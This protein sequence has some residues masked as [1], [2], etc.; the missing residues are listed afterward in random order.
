VGHYPQFCRL[1][2]FTSSSSKV[3]EDAETETIIVELSR[4]SL[5]LVR[6]DGEFI[7]YRAHSKQLE[8][9]SIL[10]LTPSSTRPSPETIE[11]INHEYSLRSELDKVWALP[12]LAI[13]SYNDRRVLVLEDPGGAPLNRVVEGPMEIMLFLRLA[14]QISDAVAQL[15]R[16]G[17]IHKDLLCL[18]Q[19]GRSRKLLKGLASPAGFEPALPP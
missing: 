18:I 16:R 15:H 4:Y 2:R 5:D 1:R 9:P 12:P 8:P 13:S 10:L 14:I 3:P 6:E 17:L 7:L 11:K 19:G